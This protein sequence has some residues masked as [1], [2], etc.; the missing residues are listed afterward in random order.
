VRVTPEL[1]DLHTLVVDPAAAK[2]GVRELLHRDW[3][4]RPVTQKGESGE[5]SLYV[6]RDQLDDDI[7]V[8]CETQISVRADRQT[9]SHK[10]PDPGGFK[11]GSE[12]LEAGK[13]HDRSLHY[14]RSMA[15]PYFFG[16]VATAAPSAT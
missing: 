11:R 6:V 8:L 12:S 4:D 10:V 15:E 13:S 5:H 2:L 1:Q 7:N 14:L 9:T 3:N 16:Q